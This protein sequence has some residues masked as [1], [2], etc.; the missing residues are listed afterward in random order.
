MKS[1]RFIKTLSV[2]FLVIVVFSYVVPVD[3]L[4][5]DTVV[6]APGAGVSI[7]QSTGEVTSGGGG[8]GFLK[9]LAEFVGTPIYVAV[10]LVMTLSFTIFQT[11][12]SILYGFAGMFFDYV[13]ELTI[14]DFATTYTN[15]FESAVVSVW[16]VL[17]DFGNIIIIFSMLYLAIRTILEGNGFADK[18]TLSLILLAA[19]LIN[20]SLFFSKIGVDISNSVAKAVY[21]GIEHPGQGSFLEAM[22][23]SFKAQKWFDVDYGFWASPENIATTAN[24]MIKSGSFIVL[25]GIIGGL[26]VAASLFLVIRTLIVVLLMATSAIGLVGN[27]IPFLRP[28]AKK[29]WEEYW[30]QLI[31]LPAFMIL[32]WISFLFMDQLK[33]VVESQTGGSIFSFAGNG[34]DLETALKNSTQTLLYYIFTSILLFLT[35]FLPG[36]IGATGGKM[37]GKVTGA[38]SS[39]AFRG[40]AQLTA[41]G[42]GVTGLKGWAQRKA[43]DKNASKFTRSLA[44]YSLRGA[45]KIGRQSMDFRNIKVGGKSVGSKLGYGESVGGYKDVAEKRDK[46]LQKQAKKDIELGNYIDKDGKKRNVYEDAGKSGA[47]QMT[48]EAQE[49]QVQISG[50]QA[51]VRAGDPGVDLDE[52][53]QLES[54]HREKLK[55]ISEIA[56]NKSLKEKV[57]SDIMK[58]DIGGISRLAEIFMESRAAGMRA[59]A[60]KIAKGKKETDKLADSLKKMLNEG[61]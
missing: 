4:A 8:T 21:V 19:V 12:V 1:G 49:M 60:G 10:Q 57:Y 44:K 11:A 56:T 40:G 3:V 38:V 61:K 59:A 50:L 37:I 14:A 23:K 30:K 18:K 47:E 16:E 46:D 9:G 34:R 25:T 35:I 48:K 39:R 54:A 41:A 20:F 51:R 31:A 45:D 15:N 33:E 42:I 43:A 29:W 17:R 2:I 53:E 6:G 5:Q 13:I 32:F 22:G 52:L 28:Y 24:S 7:S 26:F 55:K 58:K 27:L 36:K